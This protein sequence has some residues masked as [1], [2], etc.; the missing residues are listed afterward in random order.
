MLLLFSLASS[1]NVFAEADEI[2]IIYS[3]WPLQHLFLIVFLSIL[4]SILTLMQ[5]FSLLFLETILQTYFFIIS[6][7]ILVSPVTCYISFNLFSIFF[8]HLQICP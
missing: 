1:K 5:G 3:S 8:T 2:H 4:V 6:Q 7:N